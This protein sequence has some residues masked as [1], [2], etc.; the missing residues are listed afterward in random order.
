MNQRTALV[1][2]FI[3][4]FAACGGDQAPSVPTQPGT[5]T[6]LK[7][8]FDPNFICGDAGWL[9]PDG[10]QADLPTI[11]VNLHLK[12]PSSCAVN[13]L[14]GSLTWDPNVAR[15]TTLTLGPY[16][17][18]GGF[19]P[20]LTESRTASSLTFTLRR[21]NNAPDVSGDGIFLTLPFTVAPTAAAGAVTTLR[22]TSATGYPRGSL[23]TC[24]QGGRDQD[25]MVIAS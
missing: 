5:T 4:G 1:V 6:T 18:Q 13:E 25:I 16:M 11:S 3:A 24:I 20:T 9:C 2:V 23:T 17:Q 22:W 15:N 7:L 21:P 10:G 12:L 14:N 8:R 19:T